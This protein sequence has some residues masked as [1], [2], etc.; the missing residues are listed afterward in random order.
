MPTGS[1]LVP[2]VTALQRQPKP[3]DVVFIGRDASVQFDGD[4]A[5]N[6]RIIRVD[7]RQTYT[8]W[9]WL[10][11][12]QLGPRGAAVERRWIFVQLAGL[13]PGMSKRSP[14]P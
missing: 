3:G 10:H 14:T 4:R 6:F 5:F 11:G 9:V 12:Y 1:R 8:G 13:R 7:D 2:A